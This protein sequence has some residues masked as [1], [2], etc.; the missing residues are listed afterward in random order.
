MMLYQ[1][2]QHGHR[3]PSNRYRFAPAEQDLGSRIESERPE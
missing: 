3:A 1:N 2:A